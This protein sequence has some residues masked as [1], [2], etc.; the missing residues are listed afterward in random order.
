VTRC[1]L[2]P[3]PEMYS[4]DDEELDTAPNAAVRS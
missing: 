1:F 4:G 2:K 3:P